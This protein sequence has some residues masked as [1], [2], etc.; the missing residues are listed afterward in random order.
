M[1]KIQAKKELEALIKKFEALSDKERKEYNE[2][3]TRKDFVLPMFRIL[4]WDVYS[5][6]EVNEEEKASGGRVDYSF[7][8]NGLKKFYV[9]AK[10]IRVDLN[11]K[12]WAE[13]TIDYAWHKSV[14]WA[15]LSNFENLKIF[16]AEWEIA[17]PEV[18]LFKDLN[19]K[20]YI[21]KFDDL[22]LLSREASEDNLLDKIGHETGRSPKKVTI[23]KQLSADLLSWHDLLANEL[24]AF[25]KKLNKDKLEECIQKLL[26][27]LIFIRT[28]EDRGIEDKLLQSLVREYERQGKKNEILHQ[29]LRKIFRDYREYYDSKLFEEH[30]I[31]TEKFEMVEY[32]L[33]E[34]INNLYKTKSGIRYNFA[35]IPAD[36]LGTIYEQYLGHIQREGEAKDSKSKRKSQG[37]YYTPR[38]IVDY[39]VKNTVGEFIK[40]RSYN[41]ILKMKILDPA[42][43]SGSFLL[44]AFE[45]LDSYLEKEKNQTKKD[46][47]L[48]Y[49]RRIQILT[50]NI[51]GVDLDDEAVEL[52][53]LNL[54]LKTATQK[55]P[56]PDLANNIKNGNSLISGT[57]AEMKK[58]FGK[59]WEKKKPFN[60]EEEYKDV[61]DKGGFDVVIGNPPYVNLANIKDGNER[62]FLKSK[63]ETAKNKSDLYSFFVEKA[64]KLL[65]PGGFLGFIISNSWL[66]TDSFSEFRK[67]L[68]KN[69]TVIQMVRLQLGVFEDATVTPVLIFLKKEKA[70][71]KHKIKH[72]EI[73]D[74]S[75]EKISGS[76]SYERIIK[77]PNYNFSFNP[78][79][80]IKI[81]T[82]MLG[83]IAKF[84]LGIKTSND[85]KFILNGKKDDDSYKLLR[86]KDVERY[87]FNYAN[88]WIWYKPNLMMQKTGAG[89]RKLEYFLKPKIFI[90]DVATQILCTFDENNFLST[91]TLSLIYEIDQYSLKFILGLLN[92][93]FVNKWFKTNFQAGLHIKINQLEAIPIPKIN[94]SDKKE[95]AKHDELVKFVDRILKFNKELQKIDPIMDKEKYEKRKKEIEETD[96]EIDKMVYELYKL[97]PEEIKIVEGK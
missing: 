33:E 13:Q 37:I 43:G 62:E 82:V 52:T 45:E 24:G 6:N 58:Y 97:T 11:E 2:A 60:W 14:P 87:N 47:F 30:L 1:T 73:K 71:N 96:G 55:H 54:L 28:T 27:R 57:E 7:S 69:T 49:E 18:C 76:L 42:C 91:D 3:N 75:F 51:Y 74:G 53:R 19:Y 65:N 84:S 21:P 36:V 5:K 63:F 79:I 17:D 39:I 61:F 59:N 25:N 81:P 70:T 93:K 56:L 68:I 32:A 15:I 41:E 44:R 22:W 88:K 80:E 92:S 38:Y 35:Y 26:N 89:P 20:D 83:D 29:G 64:I 67:Y 85:E 48:D 72:F 16:S 4:G 40:D 10:A 34:I 66:G 9:E 94:F 95:K 77:S 86:G 50:S 8:L 23:D 31:D 12:Q 78:E 46:N 90:K